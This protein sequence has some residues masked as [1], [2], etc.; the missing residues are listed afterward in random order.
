MVGTALG[1]A[2]PCFGS[3][4]ALNREALERIGGFEAFAS[5]LADDYAIGA[6]VRKARVLR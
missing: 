4:I 2:K 1:L 5:Q 3:T 6:A